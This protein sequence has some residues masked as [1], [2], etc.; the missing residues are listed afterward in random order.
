MVQPAHR[1]MSDLQAPRGFRGIQAQLDHRVFRASR[2][3]R[4]LLALAALKVKQDLPGH[5]ARPVSR[6]I[7]VLRVCK[8]TKGQPGLR[9]FRVY[10]V[11]L[12][13]KASKVETEPLV[14]REKLVLPV[15]RV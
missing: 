14:R 1:A 7:L 4:D 8:A 9:A 2:V 5:K 15:R 6:G 3:Y 11:S 13:L 12:D 10:R